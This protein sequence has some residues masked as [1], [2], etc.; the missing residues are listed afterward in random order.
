MKR[1]SRTSSLLIVTVAGLT[2]SGCAGLIDSL[3]RPGAAEPT[4]H[5]APPPR[6][7]TPDESS[8]PVPVVYRTDSG[9]DEEAPPPRLS[10]PEDFGPTER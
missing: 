2:L 8:R 3:T 1:A 4:V 7:P 5:E 10:A 6:I 9:G